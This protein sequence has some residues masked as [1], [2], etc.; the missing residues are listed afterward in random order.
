MGMTKVEMRKLIERL[1]ALDGSD[2][3]KDHVTA[4]AILLEAVAPEIR[5]AYRKARDSG[6][7]QYA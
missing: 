2:P 3:E 5:D 4:D 7:W 1:D 6:S